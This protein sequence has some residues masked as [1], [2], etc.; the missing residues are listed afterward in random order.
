MPDL[1][2]GVRLINDTDGFEILLEKNLEKLAP[3]INVVQL[4]PD[5][6]DSSAPRKLITA[7]VLIFVLNGEN[8]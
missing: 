1:P 5:T 4:S 6:T 2:N 3:G 7:R 8:F